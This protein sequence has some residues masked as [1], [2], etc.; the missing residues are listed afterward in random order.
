MGIITYFN[1]KPKSFLMA[2]GII[3]VILIGIVNYL[4][5]VITEGER[6]DGI[7]TLPPL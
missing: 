5:A 2:L 1:R 7:R 6:S 3:L 4:E